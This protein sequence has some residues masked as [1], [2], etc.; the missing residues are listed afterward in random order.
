MLRELWSGCG[1]QFRT[2]QRSRSI[3]GTRNLGAIETRI[4]MEARL[5]R[6]YGLARA[7]PDS[8]MGVERAT[9]V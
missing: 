2:K 5:S 4:G 6:E 7:Q 9:M 3:R 1:I 8:L